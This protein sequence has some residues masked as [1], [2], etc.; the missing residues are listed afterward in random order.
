M[1][2]FQKNIETN[3]S[4]LPRAEVV[5]RKIKQQI[6][7]SEFPAGYQEL[8]PALA[9]RMGVSR[10]PVREALVRLAAEKFIDL[11]PRRGMKV[12]PLVKKDVAEVIQI[13]ESL[14]KLV[15]G[16]ISQQTLLDLTGLELANGSL[17]SALNQRD[18]EAWLIS[19]DDFYFALL[20]L[21][22]SQRL[23]EL[24]TS[25]RTQY[26]RARRVLTKSDIFMA[27]LT[28]EY[29]KMTLSIQEKNW[30]VFKESLVNVNGI[31]EKRLAN[32]FDES[33]KVTL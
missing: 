26:A 31:T 20:S 14:N 18:H 6:I 13:I 22:G 16:L 8:E 3:E 29:A 33:E 11:I 28:R 25:L 12:L 5:Y 21:A 32:A 24:F 30:S 15:V 10:T 4:D 17:E 19:D 1:N 9:Q 7:S 2:D 23:I 27:D